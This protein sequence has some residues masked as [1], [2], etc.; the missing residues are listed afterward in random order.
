MCAH[1][2]LPHLRHD[3]SIKFGTDGWRAIIAENFTFENLDRV[4][5]AYASFIREQQSD[6]PAVIVGFDNRFMSD[7]FASRV[8]AILSAQDIQVSLFGKPVPTPLLSFAV[9]VTGSNG[10]IMITASHNPAEYNGFKIKEAWGG[11]AFEEVTREVERRLDREAPRIG[12]IVKFPEPSPAVHSA[13]RE[14]IARLV[15]LEKLR[16]SKLSVVADSMHGTA[17]RYLE[18]FI[19]GSQLE[20]ETI[21]SYRDPLFGGI[22]P[23]PVDK[24]LEP[25]RTMVKLRKAT[26]GIANDGDADRLGA[27][28]E[29]G[30]TMSMH[31]VVPILLLHLTKNKQGAGKVV[32]TVSQSVL[33]KRMCNAL[34]LQW[35]ETPI[36]FKYI[37]KHMLD[38]EVLIGAEESGGI[39]IKGHI[40]ERDGI[41][42]GLLLLEAIANFGKSPAAL[43]QDIHREFGEFHYQRRDCTLAPAVGQKLV[44]ELARKP[45]A[46]VAGH[47]VS[48]V[49]TTD[50]TKLLFQ[51]ESW[52]LFRQSG[53]EPVLRLYCEATSQ[54]KACDLLDGAAAIL[55]S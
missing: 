41:L 21:R 51:D 53:T 20:I 42:N 18:D 50:G 12:K 1:G 13:Y 38:G 33:L 8:S 15:D 14:Q 24:N 43:V 49:I 39:G 26:I 35:V 29:L 16:N 30:I 5:Q 27:V 52:L 22:A 37:A 2:Q 36:G 55:K 32:F 4:T 48:Q 31:E 23:E 47:P 46:T 3:T 28:N 7:R 34:G 25:L 54:Q 17:G 9:T 10:G 19:G 40:P 44:E 11:S 45:P 6:K